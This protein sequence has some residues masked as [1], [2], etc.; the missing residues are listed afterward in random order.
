MKE[1]KELYNK[2]MHFFRQNNYNHYI[3]NNPYEEFFA[4]CNQTGYKKDLILSDLMREIESAITHRTSLDYDESQS[5]LE[6][7]QFRSNLSGVNHL[8]KL[9][10]KIKENDYF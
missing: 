10:L 4:F 5:R 2:F 1:F 8:K 6:K 7:L 9:A 3:E